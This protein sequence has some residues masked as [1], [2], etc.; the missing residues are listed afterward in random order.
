MRVW[1]AGILLGALIVSGCAGHKAQTPPVANSSDATFSDLPNSSS[2]RSSAV[3]Q[4]ALPAAAVTPAP[5]IA[6]TP[7][8]AN[9]PAP[10]LIVTP[11]TGLSGKVVRFN[12]VGR[13]VV[14]TFPIGHLP[15]RDQPL[16][17]YR[18]GLKVGEVKT[19]GFQND[20]SIVA[21]IVSGDA[22]VGDEVRDR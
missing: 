22:A 18:L 20:D 5:T 3:P 17:V 21:D 11:E 16:N 14:L 19:T 9:P 8:P 4:P 2:P 6:S 12:A 7:N 13:F 10:K 15:A 1:L